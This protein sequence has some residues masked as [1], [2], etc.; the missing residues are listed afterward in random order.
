[1]EITKTLEV[2]RKRWRM[3]LEKNHNKENE[4]WL[5]Y[6]KKYSPKQTISYE[7]AIEEALCFGWIDS[8]VKSI[9]EQRYA[10][11][12]TPR[13]EGSNLSQS[14]KQRITLLMEKGKMTKF[15]LVKVEKLMGGTFIIPHYILKMLKKDKETWE[16]FS[17]FP[18]SYK[19]TQINLI[20]SSRASDRQRKLAY[21]LKMTKLNKKIG[22][23]EQ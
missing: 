2:D 21:F 18:D 16:N 15:G 17:K 19:R 11:R 8:T 6:Y 20:A 9:D 14:N 13:K 3:W 23:P 4:I 22:D 10:Q 1:M 7:E 5:V 12:F